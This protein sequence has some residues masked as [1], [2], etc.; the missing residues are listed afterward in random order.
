MTAVFDLRLRVPLA[1]FALEVELE[2]GARR[3]GVFGPSGAGK[4]TLLEAVAGWRPVADGR[5]ALDGRVLLDTQRGIALAPE[6]RAL[7]YVPQD[8]LL[9]P[10]W[11][12]RR[13]VEAGLGR[14]AGDAR[15]HVGRV[16]ALLELSELLGRS[17][18]TLSGGE[19]RRVALARA[20]CARPRALLLDEPLAG[21][22]RPLRQRI[23]RDLLTVGEAFDLPLFLVSHDAQEVAVL[24]DEVVCLERGRLATRGTPREVFAELWRHQALEQGLENVV[25]GSVETAEG[26]VARVVLEG[27]SALLVPGAGLERGARVVLGIR[28]DEILVAM[29]RP[30]AISARNVL[31]ARAVRLDEGATAVVLRAAL[32]PAGPELDVLVTR[33]ACKDLGLRPGVACF[34]VLKSN[35]VRV[36]SMLPG[37]AAPKPG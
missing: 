22:E 8:G 9:F 21:L 19:R 27:G 20:L 18:A 12:V 3:L 29:E 31:A 7:G 6:E 1:S 10:H 32:V 14:S 28:S 35:S 24:C 16:L 34:L 11:D 36:A 23:L 5:I 26:D 30:A 2:S 4:T 33:A 13:N 25:R 37:S 17:V 15:D